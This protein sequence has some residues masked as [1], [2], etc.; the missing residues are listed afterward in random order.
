[1][2]YSGALTVDGRRRFVGKGSFI[3]PSNCRAQEELS[4]AMNLKDNILQRIDELV[5]IR[6]A[7][8]DAVTQVAFGGVA[9]VGMVYGEHSVQF[10]HLAALQK[11]CAEERDTFELGDLKRKIQGCLVALRAEVA[12]GRIVDVQ[13]EARGEVFGDFIALARKALEDSAKDVAA[14]LACA[15]LE[16]AL[17]QCAKRHGLEVDGESMLTVVNAIKSKGLIRATEAKVLEGFSKVRNDAFHARWDEIDIPCIKGI[18][19]FTETFLI[20]HF[21]SQAL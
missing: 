14:V 17:K 7:S 21:T 8:G 15:A 10:N 6:G 2:E 13:S 9:L 19:A 18:L 3:S 20:K 5:E 12:E 4:I 16:D 11:L 1:M